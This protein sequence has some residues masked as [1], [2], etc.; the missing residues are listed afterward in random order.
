M[1]LITTPDVLFKQNTVKLL[2]QS[3]NDDSFIVE[4]NK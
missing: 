1:Y 4:T 2:F 3:F